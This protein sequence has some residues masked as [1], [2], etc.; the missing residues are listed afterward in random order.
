MIVQDW[1]AAPR[2]QKTAA[3]SKWADKL[4]VSPQTLFRKLPSR[5]KRSDKG[6]R[7]IEG[8]EDAAAKVAAVKKSPPE[9]KGE[10]ATED[11]IE[12]CIANGLIPAEFADKR[13]SIDR[14]MREMGMNKRQRRIQR[15][16][17]ERPNE[18][19]HVDA[20]SSDCFYI[21]RFLEDGDC[22]LRL[23]KGH[24]TYKNKPIPTGFRPWIYGLVDDH[25]GYHVARY[26][27]AQGESAVDNL[28]FMVWAWSANEE[29]PFFGL[30]ERIKGDLGPMMRGPAAKEFFGRL[31]IS[32]DGSNP[33]NKE[34]HGKIERPWRTMW[35][36]FERPYFVEDHKNFEILLSDLNR[37]FLIY[38][39]RYNNMPHRFEKRISRVQAWQRINRQGGAVAIHPDALQTVTRRLERT[40]GADG[41]VWVDNVAYEVEGLHDAKVWIYFGLTDDDRMTVQDQRTGEKYGVKPF[42]PHALDD[43]HPAKDSPHQKAIKAVQE[44]KA[45]RPIR[46]TLYEKPTEREATPIFP[47]RTARTVEPDTVFTGDAYPSLAAAITGFCALS[48]VCL[49]Q[50]SE[51]RRA[52]ADMIIN[53]GL[54]RQFVRELALE[55]ADETESEAI[56]G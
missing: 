10:I 15:F 19:H 34:A 55:V 20:S 23:H 39:K 5:R 35:Q 6:A 18:L 30:P 17:A 54:S 53:S 49:A 16:Q 7:K 52:V 22:V 2:G 9:H 14:V 26:V 32:I 51:E 41:V 11:A 37:K 28:D 36:R 29:K 33:G 3:V 44:M 8:L 46:N 31:G 56:N 45:D 50:G 38:Q 13:S 12:I 42:K 48:G 4:G 1:D 27:A 25:S 21:H 40:V 43:F 24:H 47:T